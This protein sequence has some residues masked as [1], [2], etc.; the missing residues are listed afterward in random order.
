[1]IAKRSMRPATPAGHH[2]YWQ[3][4]LKPRARTSRLEHA[5]GV[6]GIARSTAYERLIRAGRRADEFTSLTA[7]VTTLSDNAPR[8]RQLTPDQRE[9]IDALVENGMNRGTARK[10]EYRTATS[11]KTSA[12]HASYVLPHA[13][14]TGKGGNTD[15]R[16]TEAQ[17]AR[18]HPP[19]AVRRSVEIE[20]GVV[21]GA[22]LSMTPHWSSVWRAA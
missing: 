21:V 14:A 18:S 15:H 2:A 17:L 6:L 19:I 12:P 20:A 13:S 3:Q 7:L 10:L 5:C 1:M 9:L 8:S 4:S 16:Q 11:P 22:S